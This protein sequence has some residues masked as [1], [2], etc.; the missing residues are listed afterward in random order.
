[1]T[2]H[3]GRATYPADG[4]HAEALMKKARLEGNASKA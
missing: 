1:M 3:F 4:T 2:L